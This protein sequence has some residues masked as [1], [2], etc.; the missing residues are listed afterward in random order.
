[1]EMWFFCVVFL[2]SVLRFSWI[3]LFLCFL[4]VFLLLIGKCFY[5]F[6][7]VQL[8]ALGAQKN[9]CCWLVWRP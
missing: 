9:V 6:F 7:L 1:M 5:L 3:V 8:F 2:F 4:L